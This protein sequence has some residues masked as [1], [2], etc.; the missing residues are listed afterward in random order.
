MWTA[1]PLALLLLVPQ[2]LACA[3]EN[4]P[5]TTAIRTGDEPDG[6]PVDADRT[7]PPSEDATRPV[8]AA[9]PA[10]SAPWSVDLLVRADRW[11]EGLRARLV[12]PQAPVEGAEALLE[13]WPTAVPVFEF[14]GPAGRNTAR[15]TARLA[16]GRPAVPWLVTARRPDAV[17][18]DLAWL[19]A[20]VLD[21]PSATRR[22]GRPAL[23]L[24]AG[25]LPETVRVLAQLSA[26]GVVYAVVAVDSGQAPGLPDGAAAVYLRDAAG[27][28]P[29]GQRDAT[30]EAAQRRWLDALPEV[31]APSARA[32]RNPRVTSPQAPVEPPVTDALIRSVV[33]A[34]RLAAGPRRALVLDALGGW[35]DDR[36]LDPVRF[37]EPTSAPTPLTNGVVYEAYGGAR[38]STAR[39]L[40]DTAAGPP[41][42][43]LGAPEA[44][45][46][47]TLRPSDSEATF[48][49]LS[50]GFRVALFDAQPDAPGRTEW[51]L[52]TRPFIVPVGARLTFTRTSPFVA[53]E[54]R[55][56]DGTAYSGPGAIDDAPATGPVEVSLEPLAGRRIDEVVI[57]YAGGTGRLDADVMEPRVERR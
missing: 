36:Q 48:E 29:L 39:A 28:A 37:A 47:L 43:P 16:A 33:R 10:V 53:L 35:S 32:P 26:A 5:G 4:A 52:D 50:G 30:V 54:L 22:D 46:L 17:D 20:F 24:D 7:V 23:Y 2:V 41:P 19:R 6:G 31:V 13:T 25:A 8:D 34:R 3:G 56:D 57:V 15:L 18:T 55:L 38:L 12:P 44:G 42:A 40:L 21:D 1:R 45:T 14:D 27:V 51:S 11:D 9:A 49:R